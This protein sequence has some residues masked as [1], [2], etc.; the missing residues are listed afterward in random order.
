MIRDSGAEDPVCSELLS[1]PRFRES[2][3]FEGDSEQT[4][5][6][7]PVCSPRFLR[8][9]L[10]IITENF[11]RGLGKVNSLIRYR[12]GNSYAKSAG[13]RFFPGR[14]LPREPA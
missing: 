12:A 13:L 7:K 2:Y 3:R 5:A 8:N 1:A 10:E 9:S 11:D 6:E 14:H 4:R